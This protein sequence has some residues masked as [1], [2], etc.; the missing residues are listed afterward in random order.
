[1]LKQSFYSFIK[2]YGVYNTICSYLF[3]KLE[4]HDKYHNLIKSYLVNKYAEKI[5]HYREYT[6]SLTLQSKPAEKI[7]WVL[8][9]Q[10]FEG[11]P[12]I[13]RHCL[14][15]MKNRVKDYRL[16][17][18]SK[19]NYKEYVDIPRWIIDK[20]NSGNIK[21]VHFS[22]ILR[23]YL[24]Y[25]YGGIWLDATIFLSSNLP[26]EYMDYIFFSCNSGN[27]NTKYDSRGRWCCYFMSVNHTH[28]ILFKFLK[29][30]YEAYWK[31]H[32]TIISYFLFDYLISIAYQNIPPVKEL[33]DNIP[34]NNPS[35]RMLSQKLNEPFNDEEWRKICQKTCIHKLSWKKELFKKINDKETYYYRLLAKPFSNY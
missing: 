8:W 24:L 27:G 23:V 6:G 22:D 32:D 12:E 2:E 4:M 16:I 35:I 5:N 18:L 13:V 9:W 29:D 28:T 17:M 30:M 21:I 31:K 33:I 1:M 25:Y 19:D 11:M 15:N 20:F 7:V 14:G 34:I 10:G 3:R 26:V